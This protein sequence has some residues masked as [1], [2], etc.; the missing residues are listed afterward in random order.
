MPLYPLYL[1]NGLS[2]SSYSLTVSYYSYFL[3]SVTVVFKFHKVGGRSRKRSWYALVS[4]KNFD[5]IPIEWKDECCWKR[6]LFLTSCI[7]CW[8]M[9]ENVVEQR[10]SIWSI[11]KCRTHFFFI[12]LIDQLNQEES[13]GYGLFVVKKSLR[14]YCFKFCSFES[15]GLMTWFMGHCCKLLSAWKVV[16]ETGIV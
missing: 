6:I 3:F 10:S 12:F 14:S 11:K 7:H 1:F 16:P 2:S 9:S 13:T 4:R 15:S 5:L 8:N